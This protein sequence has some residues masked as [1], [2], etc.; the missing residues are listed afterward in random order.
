[1]QQTDLQSFLPGNLLAYGDAMSM[2][3]ALELRLPLIDHRLVDVVGR[4]DPAVRI[5]GGMKALLKGVARRL[6]PETIVDLPKRGFNPP[7]GV[8]LKRDLAPMVEERL[9]RSSM[10]AL[11]LRWPAVERLLGEHR[12][13]GRDVALKVWSLL[14]LDAWSRAQ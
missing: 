8:W 4:L 6:L 14:V 10:E 11:G 2:R 5:A 13:G 1:M 7:M 3:H 9:T 12:A